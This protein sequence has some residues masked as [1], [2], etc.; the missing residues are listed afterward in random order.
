[1][2][3]KTFVSRW[4]KTKSNEDVYTSISVGAI[5]VKVNMSPKTSS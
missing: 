3:N 1:M 2:T 5:S 4:I